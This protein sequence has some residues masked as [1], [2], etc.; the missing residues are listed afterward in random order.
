MAW[1]GNSPNPGDVIPHIIGGRG[2]PTHIGGGGSH[3]GGGGSHIGGGG[4]HI[5]GGNNL[6]IALPQLPPVNDSCVQMPQVPPDDV[7]EQQLDLPSEEKVIE[8]KDDDQKQ[9][10]VNRNNY[11]QYN[12][13]LNVVVNRNHVHTLRVVKN[14]T[15]YNT[16]VTNK[17]FKVNDIHHQRIEYVPGEI[18]NID[19]CREAVSVE[20]ARCILAD[21]NLQLDL[22]RRP[23]GARVEVPRLDTTRYKKVE[24]RQSQLAEAANFA[25]NR[26]NSGSSR[27]DYPSY[28]GGRN[29]F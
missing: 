20:P 24:C 1:R 22:P 19:E 26:G 27:N 17:V 10:V 13:T 18:K 15:N 23:A 7:T 25:R 6:D 14:E 16:Y 5:G 8:T 21:N 4:S 28:G 11:T 9:I 12:K 2:S 29:Q 3:I